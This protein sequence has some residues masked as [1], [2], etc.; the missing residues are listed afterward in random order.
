VGAALLSAAIRWARWAGV[1][2]IGLSV[3]PG[4]VA[5]IRLYQRF[6]FAEEGRLT[7]HSKKSYGYED[8]I[9]MGLWL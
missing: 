2:K 7:G 9:V 6:G 5:A 4:N 1:E 8:E 3:Y